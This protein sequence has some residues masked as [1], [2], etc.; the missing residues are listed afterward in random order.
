MEAIRASK[1][2]VN[3]Y[4]TTRRSIPQDLSSSYSPPWEH[5]ISFFM[6]TF[7]FSLFK[8]GAKLIIIIFYYYIGSRA[9][10]SMIFGDRLSWLVS[11]CIFLTLQANATKLFQAGHGR[12]DSHPSKLIGRNYPVFKLSLRKPPGRLYF[13]EPVHIRYYTNFVIFKLR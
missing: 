4:V 13:S 2:S 6:N 1:T 7:V 11:S 3:F 12:C 5:E 10:C 9:L 8:R